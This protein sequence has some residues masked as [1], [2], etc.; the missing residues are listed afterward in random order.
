[1]HKW[2]LI[3]GMRDKNMSCESGSVPRR[4]RRPKCRLPCSQPAIY[5][6]TMRDTNDEDDDLVFQ[7]RIHN[8]VILAGMNTAQIR[9]AFRLAGRSTV[10]IFGKQ[11]DPVAPRAFGC[12]QA[13][14]RPVAQ[15]CW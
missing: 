7:D 4:V 10:W 8:H 11:A 9:I 6:S 14:L 12:V 2:Q 13:V 3:F 1:M 15:L 5:L